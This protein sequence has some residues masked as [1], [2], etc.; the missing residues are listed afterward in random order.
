[1]KALL[2]RLANMMT[3]LNIWFA[4]LSNWQFVA[5]AAAVELCVLVVFDCVVALTTGHANLSFNIFYDVVFA[6]VFTALLACKRWK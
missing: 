6:A 4:R 1:M 3:D 5:A 2:T